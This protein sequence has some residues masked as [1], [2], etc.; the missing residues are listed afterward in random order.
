MSRDLE[1]FFLFHLKVLA[2]I[3]IIHYSTRIIS[4]DINWY[5]LSMQN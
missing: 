5:Q 1:Q 3:S 4:L 2:N